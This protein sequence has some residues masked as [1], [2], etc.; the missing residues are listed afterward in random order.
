MQTQCTTYGHI[1]DFLNAARYRARALRHRPTVRGADG[2]ADCVV[3]HLLDLWL[4]EMLP[5]TLPHVIAGVESDET[6]A[7]IANCFAP[8]AQL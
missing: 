1:L 8:N 4:L 2:A 3:M 6:E 5:G 7:R